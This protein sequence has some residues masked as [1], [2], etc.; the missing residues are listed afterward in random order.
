MNLDADLLDLVMIL[1][2]VLRQ[3]PWLAKMDK[4]QYDRPE[5]AA[6]QDKFSPRR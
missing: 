6:T 2:V 1:H 4:G 3:Q 5:F